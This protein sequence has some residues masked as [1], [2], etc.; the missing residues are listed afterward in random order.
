MVEPSKR[1][2][3]LAAQFLEIANRYTASGWIE[4]L[5]WEVAEGTRERPFVFLEMLPTEELA[6]LHALRDEAKI[7][8]LWHNERWNPIP[9]DKWR[10]HASQR[11]AN[12]VLDELHAGALK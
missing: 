4:F 8:F 1:N 12:T 9:I 6:V 3:Q 10:A 7:W 5:L 2:V 11:T